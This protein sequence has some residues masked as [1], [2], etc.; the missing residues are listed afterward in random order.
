MR[1]QTWTLLVVLMIVFG[2]GQAEAYPVGGLD[3]KQLSEQSDWIGVGRVVSVKPGA[4]ATRRET[5][6]TTWHEPLKVQL[7][8]AVLA[9]ELVLKGEMPAGQRL[10][11]RFITNPPSDR[12]STGPFF[13]SFKEGRRLMVCLKTIDGAL[14][15][16]NPMNLSGLVL[17]DELQLPAV[18][19]TNSL[20]KLEDFAVGLIEKGDSSVRREVL[21]LIGHY[22]ATPQ[23]TAPAPG[24]LAGN[25]ALPET[26]PRLAALLISPDRNLRLATA[27]LL[28]EYQFLPALSV[29]VNELAEKDAWYPPGT[30]GGTGEA[31]AIECM[32]SHEA[33]PMLYQLMKSPQM[34]IRQA[35]TVAVWQ[36][37][38]KESIPY[39]VA[40]LDDDYAII[41]AYAQMALALISGEGKA[42]STD[43]F[44][45]DEA[46]YISFWKTWWA[47]RQGAPTE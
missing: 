29:L 18:R 34:F 39:L 6:G 35:A 43:V 32:F 27:K 24:R 47:K 13:A 20:E 15:P 19:G 26:A 4:M 42:V 41:R 8:D 25:F 3:L 44:M 37:G 45:K 10:A 7:N 12:P 14:E 46:S 38:S 23:K 17:P 33:L 1:D 16:I 21:R 31:M 11:W 2:V 28:V 9:V 40:A 5:G 22:Q 36:E 30:Y